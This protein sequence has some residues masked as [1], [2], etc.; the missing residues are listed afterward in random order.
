MVKRSLNLDNAVPVKRRKQSQASQGTDHH[1]PQAAG[2]IRKIELRNF[3]NHASLSFDFQPRVNFVTGRNGTGKSALL[4]GLMVG[5]G[6]KASATSRG[7]QLAGFVQYGKNVSDTK[8]TLG[9]TGPDAY[10]PEVY[11]ESI[12]V[13]RKLMAKSGSGDYKIKTESGQLVS[14]KKADL[15]R[16]LDHF[17]IQVE[18]PVAILNQETSKNFLLSKNPSDVYKFFIKAT[19]LE[20]MQHGYTNANKEFLASMD[21]LKSKE[22][23]L[24]ALELEVKQAKE[25]A[26]A[27]ESLDRL[28]TKLESKQ[29]ELAWAVVQQKEN[30]YTFM[31]E[32][33]SKL[34]AS[35]PKY[36]NEVAKSL[37]KIEEAEGV[38]RDVEKRIKLMAGDT[39]TLAPKKAELKKEQQA[40]KLMTRTHAE[41]VRHIQMEI[42]RQTNDQKQ[43]QDRINILQASSQ[44]DKSA[45]IKERDLKLKKLEAKLLEMNGKC[46]TIR[47]DLQDANQA[48]AGLRSEK[49]EQVSSVNECDNLKKRHQAKIGQLE[50]LKSNKSLKFGRSVPALVEAIDRLHRAGR[51]TKK[52]LGPIGAHIT[53]KDMKYAL[54]AERALGSVMTSFYVN[55]KS[56][57]KLLNQIKREVCGNERPPDVLIGKF[58]EKRYEGITETKAKTH[59]PTLMDLLNIDSNCVFNCLIDQVAIHRVVMVLD[60]KEAR[61]LMFQRQPKNSL[62]CFDG[63]GDEIRAKPDRVFANPNKRPNYMSAN[64]E[65]DIREETKQLKE[66]GQTLRKAQTELDRIT[67]QIQANHE[68]SLRLKTSL[69]S[70]ERQQ[71][72]IEAEQEMVRSQ[73]IEEEEPEDV[74][75]LTSDVQNTEKEL[76]QLRENLN[77]AKEKYNSNKGEEARVSKQ[78]AEISSRIEKMNSSIDPLKTEL[79]AAEDM[80]DQAKSDSI[81]YKDKLKKFDE[82]IKTEETAL[83]NYLKDQVEKDM[84][85]ASQ[86]SQRV[87]TRKSP[88]SLQAEIKKMKGQ[89]SKEEE[90]RGDADEIRAQLNTVNAKYANAKKQL[91]Q[92]LIYRDEMKKALKLRRTN[93]H[94]ITISHAESIKMYFVRYLHQRNY[95]GKLQFDFDEQK[96]EIKVYPPS[97]ST[98][99]ESDNKDLRGLSGGEKSFSTLCFIMS[100]WDSVASPIRCMDEFDVFM[101][102]V[103]RRISIKMLIEFAKTNP[104][105]QFILLTPQDTSQIEPNDFVHIYRMPDPKRGG[106]DQGDS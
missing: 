92:C 32:K 15:T 87:K 7:N 12:V 10:H 27:L 79:S 44:D 99:R 63:S 17:N 22:S 31:Q 35:R 57:A 54:G 104:S 8:V 3:M 78:L 75:A 80:I 89:I 45:Q 98:S 64:V 69:G 29:C 40:K 88:E 6:G 48:L 65:E 91:A 25:R 30:E 1:G 106:G 84:E 102:M 86:M 55:H 95:D 96:L 83:S 38:K 61:N 56:D 85:I 41:A 47:K 74:Q 51:F 26:A 36:Q 4:T 23:I 9:N 49:N 71:R 66:V 103:N 72:K 59:H 90:L 58:T 101:D 2:I 14:S 46:A 34:Q 73:V 5:L 52:P 81:Y 50:T 97:G 94:R 93:M 24:P 28:R 20:Q 53:I 18:N 33:V 37:K 82:K 62:V 42:A 77:N 21:T 76:A 60:G 105:N 68:K 70:L 13:E 100:L 16:I 43:M 39:D 67:L 19:K 11:G